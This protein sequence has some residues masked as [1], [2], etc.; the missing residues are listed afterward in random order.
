MCITT[1]V[2]TRRNKDAC[3]GVVSTLLQDWL[4]PLGNTAHCGMSKAATG[5][6]SLP[7]CLLC[8]ACQTL[9]FTCIC[10]V[11]CDLETALLLLDPERSL[12]YQVLI[13]IQA[14]C[15][16]L[17][18]GQSAA[19]PPCSRHLPRAAARQQPRL[20]LL[21][22]TAHLALVHIAPAVSAK[23]CLQIYIPQYVTSQN[24]AFTLQ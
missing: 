7:Q 3:A 11:V 22:W 16:G 14:G 5:I 10:N 20:T 6:Q 18:S 19:L 4:V 13:T 23:P 21:G 12:C 15:L 9:L 24:T 17:S 1:L 8:S 2:K